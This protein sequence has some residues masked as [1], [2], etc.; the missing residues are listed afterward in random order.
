MVG[1]P[2]HSYLISFPKI[3]GT[4]GDGDEVADLST[5]FVG[6]QIRFVDR[7]FCG[8]SEVLAKIRSLCTSAI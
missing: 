4:E 2:L 6:M 8:R 3:T 1:K 5:T 7:R